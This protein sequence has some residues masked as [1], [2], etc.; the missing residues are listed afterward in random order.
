MVC[1]YSTLL[2]CLNLDITCIQRLANPTQIKN[3]KQ[4]YCRLYYIL[5][6][7]SCFCIF[8]VY[9]LTY[10]DYLLPKIFHTKV[11]NFNFKDTLP[12]LSTFSKK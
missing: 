11:V 9:V 10:F 5:C 12:V 8:S 4:Q 1:I 7:V 6:I 2:T 3:T